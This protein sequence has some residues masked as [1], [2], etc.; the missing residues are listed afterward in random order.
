MNDNSDRRQKKTEVS[1]RLHQI[2]YEDEGLLTGSSLQVILGYVHRTQ[3]SFLHHRG[4]AFS[5]NVDTTYHPSLWFMC[6]R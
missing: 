2:R 3:G 6:F 1:L 5:N 4:F